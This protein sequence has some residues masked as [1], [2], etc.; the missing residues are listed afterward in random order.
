MLNTVHSGIGSIVGALYLLVSYDRN[1]VSS[2]M[3]KTVQ[4]ARCWF[5]VMSGKTIIYTDPVDLN[6]L[7]QVS[8]S[9]YFEV[10]SSGQTPL[11]SFISLTNV[12]SA[13]CSALTR[14][15]PTPTITTFM[16]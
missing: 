2:E 4:K 13:D 5:G 10:F 16:L 15:S 3:D 8:L 9:S 6:S 11:L 1:I 7:H 14:C 12:P